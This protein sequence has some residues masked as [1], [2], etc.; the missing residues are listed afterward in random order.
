MV[1]WSMAVALASH[2]FLGCTI[3]PKD[4]FQWRYINESFKVVLSLN[5]SIFVYSLFLPFQKKSQILDRRYLVAL[6]IWVFSHRPILSQPSWALEVL[7]DPYH[8][9]TWPNKHL[10]LRSPTPTPCNEIYIHIYY[11]K[12]KISAVY[13]QIKKIKGT[14][15]RRKKREGSKNRSCVSGVTACTRP[16]LWKSQSKRV[17]EIRKKEENEENWFTGASGW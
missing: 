11:P 13:K 16:Y 1:A 4:A 5:F 12:F 9:F 8:I 17:L 10:K 2:H 6:L 14:Q 15:I 7:T 3:L